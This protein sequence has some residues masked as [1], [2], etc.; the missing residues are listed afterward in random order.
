MT[1]SITPLQIAAL[2]VLTWPPEGQAVACACPRCAGEGCDK[3]SQTGL[4]EFCSADVGTPDEKPQP[5]DSRCADTGAPGFPQGSAPDG[6]SDSGAAVIPIRGHA[7]RHAGADPEAPGAILRAFDL[8]G[9]ARTEEEI[10]E[11]L[12]LATVCTGLDSDATFDEGYYRGVADAIRWIIGETDDPP[13][14][15]DDV[16]NRP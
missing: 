2:Q 8:N 1:V 14:D 7:A 3:C 16:M 12:A 13:L 10:A 5:P 6:G 4:A 9:L 15:A 11:M